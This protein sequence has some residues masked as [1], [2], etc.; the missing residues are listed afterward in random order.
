[1]KASGYLRF[2]TVLF[3][4]TWGLTLLLVRGS[5]SYALSGTT[6][7]SLDRGADLA[8]STDRFVQVIATPEYDLAVAYR[9]YGVPSYWY[10]L[11]EYDR[12]V[13]VKSDQPL[14]RRSG[15]QTFQGRLRSVAGT[16]FAGRV[17]ERF[18]QEKGVRIPAGGYV[19]AADEPPQLFTP[20]LVLVVPATLV[21]LG[22]LVLVGRSAFRALR[23][24]RDRR[25]GHVRG[26]GVA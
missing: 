19:I 8:A 11:A 10:P 25:R 6:P 5:L 17:L 20:M 13:I 14:P 18:L 22:L 9:R 15:P 26:A 4:V 2:L 3:I 1:M 23:G 16:A 21:W 12:Q 7:L 24:Q